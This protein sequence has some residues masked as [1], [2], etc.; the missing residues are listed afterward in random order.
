MMRKTGILTICIF[1]I[2]LIECKS[3][4]PKTINESIIRQIAEN[5]LTRRGSI[6]THLL[7]KQVSYEIY[8]IEQIKDP[9]DNTLI[10]H[11]VRV[12][13]TGFVII[14][15]EPNDKPVIA[16]SFHNDWN[17]ELRV[18]HWIYDLLKLDLDLRK[19][20]SGESY[21]QSMQITTRD[22]VFQTDSYDYYSW[23]DHYDHGTKIGWGWLQTTWDQG[24]PYN[25]F[26]PLD[27][28]KR[29]W[30]GCVAT[31]MAQIV[32]YHG[33]PI[34]LNFDYEKD[35]Y[36]TY[37]G[38]DIDENSIEND[39]PDF[40]Q[41]N[42]YIQDINNKFNSGEALD[43]I[44]K[45]ALCFACGVSV[46]LNYSENQSYLYSS[47][48]ANIKQSFTNKMG[49]FCADHMGFELYRFEF[50]STLIK[51]ITN[52]L[53]AIIIIKGSKGSHA[54]VVDG[55]TI[56]GFF[57]LN[58]GRGSESP[59]PII[60]MWW[61]GIPDSLP[62]NYNQII[63]GT[64]NITPLEPQID[65]DIEVSSHYIYFDE[66][67]PINEG[68]V[69]YFTLKNIGD[70]PLIIKYIIP[71][72]NISFS[73]LNPEHPVEYKPML[74]SNDIQEVQLVWRPDRIGIMNERLQ[75]F[76]SSTW[77]EGENEY[78]V[79]NL[80]GTA[81]EPKES[82]PPGDISDRVWGKDIKI[83]NI[84]GNINIPEGEKLIIEAGT[85]IIF[86]GPYQFSINQNAQLI[87]KGTETDSI[88]FTDDDENEG[89]QGLVF[90]DSG[91][92]D[93]LEYCVLSHANRTATS[94]IQRGGVI[95][96]DNSNPTITHS[97]ITENKT[98][99]DGGGMYL[100]NSNATIR[101]TRFE[102]NMC[103][104]NGNGGALC[105]VNSSP[106]ITNSIFCNNHANSG[107]AIYVTKSSPTL[108]NVTI[109]D[110]KALTNGGAITLEKDYQ[111]TIENSIIWANEAQNGS[112]LAIS[113]S[114]LL[115]SI[116]FDYSDIDTTNPNWLFS[117]GQ[118]HISWGPGILCTDPLFTNEYNCSYTLQEESPCIDS[119]DPNPIYNDIEDPE[120][121]GYALR[122]A[123]GTLRNDM[124]AYG[125]NGGIWLKTNREMVLPPST[126]ALYQNYPNPF[127]PKTV[128]SWQL[129]VGSHVELCIYN[130]L[131]QK[132]KTLLNKPM[133]A[134]YHEVEFN[135]QDLSSGIYLYRIEAGGWK[136]V[137]KMILIR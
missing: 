53:P 24:D 135:G 103:P 122:P 39:F 46:R 13:P 57:H 132:I 19:E 118:A 34:L 45:A 109:A 74:K 21:P 2:I 86:K 42:S 84:Q 36:T 95:S 133:P 88:E 97:R 121:L 4:F 70:W 18:G 30:V 83:Y 48:V 17:V 59:K 116:L 31:A 63:N 101:Y 3:V 87:A 134:G 60:D 119:G 16:Y 99:R 25:K 115:D 66:E 100:Y 5:F 94:T 110:N 54:I 69:R 85:K 40:S 120:N 38:V 108:T 123:K 20:I 68:S 37:Q 41:L 43:D 129:A 10:A 81:T 91:D 77:R 15:P 128:I 23:P 14:S 58:Y 26:C 28:S 78:L 50:F 137:K 73:Y 35:H 93:T 92:D 8:K 12:Q 82:I 49:Y 27:T 102:G 64:L 104:N 76:A 90:E 7:K 114:S 44:E 117:S 80:K 33:L 113:S 29:S 125:G 52:A 112:T 61:N 127:N 131:G 67:I 62:D 51:N 79:I 72:K 9:Q 56:D 75:I 6:Q 32:N 107:G 136:D 124:G 105:M 1:V 98:W 55:Y 96:I 11:I 47:D 111:I 130:I 22:E 106:I 71:P 126:I 65:I 89:W